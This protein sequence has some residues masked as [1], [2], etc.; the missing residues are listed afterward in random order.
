MKKILTLFSLFLSIAL[1]SGCGGGSDSPELYTCNGIVVPYTNIISASCTP[2]T[3]SSPVTNEGK[4]CRTVFFD[5]DPLTQQA[6][7]F[8]VLTPVNTNYCVPANATFSCTP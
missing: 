5:Y 6:K 4:C 7:Q 3:P 2:I 8:T 1:I